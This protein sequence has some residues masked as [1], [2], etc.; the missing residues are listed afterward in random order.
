MQRRTTA[1]LRTAAVLASVALVATGC[2][3]GGGESGE[4]GSGEEVALTYQTPDGQCEAGPTEGVDYDTANELIQSFQ[5]PS[6]GLIQTEPLPTPVGPDFTV[7]FLN[8]DTAVAG[9]MYASMEL[10]ADA[11]GVELV[12]VSTGTDA[13]SINSALNSVV[14]L[15]PDAVISVAIDATFYQDQLEQLEAKGIP[16][17]Y[18][19]QGNAEEFGLDDTLGGLNASLV[20]GQVLAAGAVAFTCGTGDEFVFYNVPELTFS[21]IQLEAAQEYLAELCADCSL[22]VVDISIIDPSPADKIVSDLQSNPETDFFITPVDQYQIGL[23]DKAQLAGLTNAYGFGQSSLPPN[24]QQLAD[25]LQ[26]AGFAVDLNMFMWLLLDEAF[27]KAQGVYEPYTDWDAV[28][29]SVSLV[30][31]PENAGQYVAGFEAYPGMEDDF[32]ALWGK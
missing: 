22:R 17:V 1:A 9:I 30:L 7:A 8:N 31:T 27:R 6:T 20:N 24:V 14:E 23:G 26:T 13:Q 12:N 18:A 3:A 15:E 21:A 28:N 19:S 11:A 4:G 16:V 5:E 29:R 10:A 2:S 25:G 32:K